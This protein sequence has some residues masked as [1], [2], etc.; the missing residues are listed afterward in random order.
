MRVG[1]GDLRDRWTFQQ[2]A[3][4][5][6]GDRRGPWEDGFSVSAKVTWL[7]GS[8]AVM[9]DRLTGRQPVVLTIRES[10][11]SRQITPGWRAFDARRAGR[12]AN[13]TA[14]SPSKTRG[15]LDV[16]AVIGVAQG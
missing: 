5:A 3:A 16:L 4:D 8:E 9:Q 7:I 6:N 11:V 14:V 1:A 13:I 10:S 12:E 2:R 15:F